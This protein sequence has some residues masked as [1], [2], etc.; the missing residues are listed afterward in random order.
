MGHTR[1]YILMAGMTALFLTVGALLG[2]RAGMLIA[3]VIAGGLNL[4]AWWNSGASVLRRYRAQP[5]TA[6]DPY[7]G[8]FYRDTADMAQRAGL[9]LPTI[10]VIPADQPNAFATG[11]NPANAAV[12]ATTGLLGS[13]TR[14]EVAGVMAHELAHVKNRDTLTMT[15]AASLAGAIG[16]LGNFAM[17][18]G[19]NR[20]VHPLLA[21]AL[22]VLAPLAAMMV[23][24]AI[25]RV[26]EYAADKQ[27]AAICGHPEWLASAL[28]KIGGAKVPNPVADRDPASAHLFIA[29]P[30]SG[31][32]LASLF[33][34]HPPM[35]ERIQRLMAMSQL[36]AH[37]TS[38]NPWA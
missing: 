11:R 1:T 15:I 9:P 31:R 6:D 30:L 10:C 5:I 35:T 4:Y 17:L 2:G 19:R 3:L 18:G 22:M 34:T 38:G 28:A 25:S 33:R 29:N 37:A 24:M 13:L 16:F 23:Q 12:C 26:R 27:G 21:M 14:E 20:S 32:A 8:W 7:Y 36:P